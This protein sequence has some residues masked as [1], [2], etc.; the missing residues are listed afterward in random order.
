MVRRSSNVA[1]RVVLGLGAVCAVVMTLAC[2]RGN[3]KPIDI[4]DF[5]ETARMNDSLQKLVPAG[6]TIA[7]AQTLMEQSGFKCD[8]ARRSTITVDTVPGKLGAGPPRL[9]CWNS[10]RFF[11]WF[12][13]RD[14]TVVYR[15]DSAG[16]RDV[17]A[18][19]II[20]P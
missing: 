10:N 7:Q 14:W 8:P 16:I 18:S 11:P 15:Y 6:T 9:E 1:L 13:H 17:T 5:S 12:Q 20:Q 3:Q 2:E 4:R 19:Y